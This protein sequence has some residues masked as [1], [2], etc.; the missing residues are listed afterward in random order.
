MSEEVSG[1]TRQPLRR[2]IIK[3][4]WLGVPLVILGESGHLLLKWA[5]EQLA[6]HFF[7]IVFGIGAGVV[8]FSFVIRDIIHNGW[9]EFSWRLHP[10][11]PKSHPGDLTA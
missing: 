2:W 5:Q 7:H 8:F 1:P 6:H 9:P 11:R 3:L 4:A 10:D